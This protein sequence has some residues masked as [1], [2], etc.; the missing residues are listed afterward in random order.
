M[1]DEELAERESKLLAEAKEAEDA[2]RRR[3]QSL[4]DTRA[5]RDRLA[6]IVESA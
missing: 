3:K 2:V 4:A 5:L 1:T 6:R